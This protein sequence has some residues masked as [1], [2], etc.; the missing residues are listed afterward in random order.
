[1]S[2]TSYPVHANK[3]QKLTSTMY[4]GHYNPASKPTSTDSKTNKPVHPL[5]KIYV[6]RCADEECKF[7]NET[8]GT[9][10]GRYRTLPSGNQLREPCWY[11]EKCGM[12]L[13]K[14]SRGCCLLEVRLLEV[15][16][17]EV[18]IRIEKGSAEGKRKERVDEDMG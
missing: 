9:E 4:A 17:K 5:L 6:W 15:V 7:T 2:A 3:R 16:E 13:Q 1:M 14:A 8:M 11:D 10:E 12:C 18:E